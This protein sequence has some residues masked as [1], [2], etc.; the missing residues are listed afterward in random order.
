MGNTL[1]IYDNDGFAAIS[2]N[3]NVIFEDLFLEMVQ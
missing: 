2:D 3:I 1:P